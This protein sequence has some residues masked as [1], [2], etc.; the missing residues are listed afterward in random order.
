[1]S[2]FLTLFLQGLVYG[3]IGAISYLVVGR[4]LK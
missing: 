2:E 3:V 4:F 1:M